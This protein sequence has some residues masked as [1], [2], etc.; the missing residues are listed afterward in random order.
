ME[1]K[2]ICTQPYNGFSSAKNFIVIFPKNFALI[3]S[4]AIEDFSNSEI[5][6]SDK[7]MNLWVNKCNYKVDYSVGYFAD[8]KS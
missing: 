6:M 2:D 5:Y 8:I 1:A 3:N 7:L 4:D